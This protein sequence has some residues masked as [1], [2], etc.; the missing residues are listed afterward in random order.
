MGIK[1]KV[2]V[3]LVVLLL[4]PGVSHALTI[5]QKALIGLKGI[6]IDIVETSPE[7]KRLGLTPAQIKT[8]VELR[9]RKAG[10]KVLTDK[11]RQETPGFPFLQVT[12]TTMVSQDS[13]LLVFSIAVDL[14]E[15]V[16]LA[17][18]GETWGQIWHTSSTGKGGVNHIRNL[19]ESVG[20]KVDEFI[21]DYL[22]ANPKK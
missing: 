11:E 1:M 22:A 2:V 18:G 19:R 9:L 21:N 7:V 4:L 8:D 5:K 6:G 10:I 16:M 3:A 15:W 17:R 14:I 20:D 13:A 12:V